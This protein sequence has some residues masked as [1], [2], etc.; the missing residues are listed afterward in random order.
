M[1]KNKQGKLGLFLKVEI[2]ID[3]KRRASTD[4]GVKTCEKNQFGRNEATKMG[5][6][7]TGTKM[8]FGL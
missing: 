5:N 4:F 2:F 8:I 1:L 7:H 3:S 6:Y